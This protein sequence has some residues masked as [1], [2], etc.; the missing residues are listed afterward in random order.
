MVLSVLVYIRDEGDHRVLEMVYPI[1]VSN[2]DLSSKTHS[3]TSLKEMAFQVH[4]VTFW[5]ILA[6]LLSSNQFCSHKKCLIPRIL[7]TPPAYFN[8]LTY[9]S[10][11]S[12][13]HN[14]KVPK[15]TLLYS[16]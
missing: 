15:K 10:I 1:A 4:N 5:M 3:I 11:Q 6:F 7:I 2:F 16:Q 9:I 8:I 12:P 14:L 13:Y